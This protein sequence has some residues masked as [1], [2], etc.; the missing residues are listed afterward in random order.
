MPG[1]SGTLTAFRRAVAAAITP[2]R[3]TNVKHYDLG[4][5]D[6]IQF[7]RISIEVRNIRYY[8]TIG[9]CSRAD[10][11]GAIVIEVSAG[12]PQDVSDML[13]EFTDPYSEQSAVAL[14]M[15]GA[16]EIPPF[17]GACQSFVALECQRDPGTGVAEIPFTASLTRPAT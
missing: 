17:G 5:S 9:T 15:Q 14:V 6:Q 12:T 1:S 2:P 16:A 13:D 8:Q 4:D 7:P 10:I 3:G 11:E